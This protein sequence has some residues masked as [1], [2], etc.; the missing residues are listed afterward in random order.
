MRHFLIAL[1]FA[2][3]AVQAQTVS[4]HGHLIPQR[5][6]DS[7]PAALRELHSRLAAYAVAYTPGETRIYYYNANSERSERPASGGYYRKTLG[8]TAAGLRVVQDYYQDSHLPQTSPLVL[9][10][11]ATEDDFSEDVIDNTFARYDY[12][13]DGAAIRITESADGIDGRTA[14]YDRGQLVIESPLPEEADLEEDGFPA[15]HDYAYSHGRLYYPDGKLLLLI[16]LKRGGVR[17]IS[18]LYRKDGSLLLTQS[19]GTNG[20]S[21][22]LWNRAGKRIPE[23]SADWHQAAEEVEQLREYI[24]G[25]YQRLRQHQEPTWRVRF[26]TP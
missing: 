24:D 19:D 25:L 8:T 20:M 21:I 10:A 15:F 16:P 3:L 14:Y 2:C 18:M 4:I 1:T 17:P 11:D 22:R 26:T 12:T 6:E 23:D 13:R 5:S 9:R 7:A